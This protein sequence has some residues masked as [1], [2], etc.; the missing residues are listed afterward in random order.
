MFFRLCKVNLCNFYILKNKLF[1]NFYKDKEKCLFDLF[2]E[3]LFC[4]M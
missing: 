2:L 1:F 3:F 4:Y